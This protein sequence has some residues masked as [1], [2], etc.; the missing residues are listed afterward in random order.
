MDMV[1][2]YKKQDIDKGRD[3]SENIDEKDFDYFKDLLENSVCLICNEGFSDL[4]K[5]T[6]DRKNNS[7]SHRKWNV[8]PC[9]CYCNKFKSSK[10][11]NTQKLYIQI[12]KFEVKKI[13]H[14]P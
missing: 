2:R 3:V 1:N 4:N 9:C 7:L 6:L 11:E 5:P 8:K 14:V 12:R 10:D 13:F